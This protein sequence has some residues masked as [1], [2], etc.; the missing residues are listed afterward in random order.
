M[1]GQHQVLTARLLVHLGEMDSRGLYR[2]H[3]FASMFAYAVEELHMSEAEAYLRIQAARLGRQY[4]IIIR[5]L[6]AGELHLTAIK[7]L[8]PHLTPGNHV[9]VLERAR[10]KGKREIE[11]IVA[12]LAPKPDVP[13]VVRKLP[14][15]AIAQPADRATNPVPAPRSRL[16]QRPK[17]AWGSVC[18]PRSRRARS[19]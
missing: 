12:E 17:C 3:A 18:K 6:A 5:M 16:S 11:L 14:S 9:Q 1:V 2:E 19:T 7:L 8:G 10:F 13:S 15:P 4:P